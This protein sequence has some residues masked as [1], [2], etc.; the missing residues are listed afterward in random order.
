MNC[1]LRPT[2]TLLLTALCL[3]A[4]P[5]SSKAQF[6]QV[7]DV[8]SGPYN[9]QSLISNVFLGAGVEVT[10]I[11]FNGDPR[12][13]GYFS[14]GTQSLGIE[15]GIV[16]TSGFA[17]QAELVGGTFAN[18][19]NIGGTFEASL[20]AIATDVLNDVAVYT[21]T[22]IPNADTL[23]FRYSFASEEYPEYACTAF[24]DV[25]GFF[26]QGP[27]YPVYTNIARVPG[28][29]LP[30]SIN[31]IHPNNPAAPP[32]PPLNVQYYNDNLGSS[33]QPVYDG[34]TDVFTAMA[35]VTPCQP[36]TIKLA[37]ADVGDGAYDSGVFLEAKSFGTGSLLVNATTVSADGTIAEGCV[38]GSVTFTLPEIRSQNYQVVFN[39]FGTATPGTDYQAI[40]NNLTIPAGQSTITVP[41]SA[42]EDGIAESPE[43]IGISVQVDPCNRD[44]VFLFIRDKI[45]LPPLLVDTSTCLPNTPV[46]LN[47]TVPTPVPPPP[48]FTNQTD[49]NIPNGGNPVNSS[50]NVF[51]VQPPVVGPGVIRSV[52]INVEHSWIDE[53]DAYLISPGGVVVELTT[54]NGANGDNYTNTCFTPTATTLISFPGPFAPASAAPFTGDWLPEG[55]W[56]DLWGEPSNG[57]WRLRLTDDQNN[58]LGK[59]LDWTITFEPNYNVTY[60]WSPGGGLS[61]TDCPNPVANVAQTSVYNVTATDS[62]GCTVTED[63]E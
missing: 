34:F 3:F 51:G 30:V 7:T 21:I 17:G 28:T 42:F 13:V 40:P 27:G 44:T 6:L 59:L 29:M 2:Q 37:I 57:N 19:G 41:I 36:Y 12:S 35:V 54:D 14:G 4:L 20:E 49:Y 50:I 15:R 18:N 26:I 60:A 8:V 45:L 43:S 52:C 25:F 9:P 24:N 10:N 31:N 16:L 5:F 32:C 53:V 38:P 61:C 58:I 46:Q 11:T 47:A 62:Y 56:S 22:F 23:R 48:A 39:V 63:I 33:L 1:L 55:P